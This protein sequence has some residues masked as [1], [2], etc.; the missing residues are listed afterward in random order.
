MQ[1]HPKDEQN[2]EHR[3]HNLKKKLFFFFSFF[4]ICLL[5]IQC[6]DFILIDVF[7]CW[8]LAKCGQSE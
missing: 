7:E 1:M 5:V 6:Y 8:R 4:F 2:K 3:G